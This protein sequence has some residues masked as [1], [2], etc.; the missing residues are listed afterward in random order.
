M[1]KTLKTIGWICL[2]LGVLGILASAGA[3]V[4]GRQFTAD[5]QAAIA[6]VRE[7]TQDN[8]R[9]ARNQLC[10]TEDADGDGKPDGECIQQPDWLQGFALRQGV[11]AGRRLMQSSRPLVNR[12]A[13]FGFGGLPI[14]LFVLGPVLTVIGAVILLV[15]RESKEKIGVE[16]E[17][18]TAKSKS[19]K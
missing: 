2:A 11:Q 13:A 18:K 5:R 10:I 15:N 4:I 8:D 19:V 16:D 3:L 17:K 14:F 1:N 9:P 12:T 7:K 6:E